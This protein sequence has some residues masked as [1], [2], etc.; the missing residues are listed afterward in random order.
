LRRTENPEELDRYQLVPLFFKSCNVAG[1]NPALHTNKIT[2]YTKKVKVVVYLD[3][4]YQRSKSIYVDEGT[5][6]EDISK[7]V[8][9]KFKDWFSW[10]LI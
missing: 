9:E 10:D 8:N 2:M 4:S 6:K 5:S 3:S 1:S 7:E